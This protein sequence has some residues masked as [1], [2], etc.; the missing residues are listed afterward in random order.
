MM[1]WNEKTAEDYLMEI[2][3]WTRKKNTLGQVRDYLTEMGD[4]DE[5]LAI[6]HVAGTNGK[7]SVCADLT[8]ILRE[9]GFRVGTF[10]SPHLTN[11]RERFLID[12]QPVGQ[13][14]FQSAFERV[15]PV[16]ERMQARGYC[17]PTFFEYL[18][19]M[20]M[21]LFSREA[22][23]YVILETGLGGRLDTTNVIRHPLACVITSISLDHTAYLGDT[24]PAIAAEKAGIIKPNVPV[25]YDASEPA[26]APVIHAR[27]E[28][29]QAPAYPVTDQERYRQ[30]NFSAPYQERNAALAVK[31]LQVLQLPGVDET[32]CKRALSTVSWQG[33]MESLG[34]GI[35]LDGAHN[36][37]GIRAFL[38]AADRLPGGAETKNH[39]L[40]AAVADKDY[41]E[42]VTLLCQ[43]LSPERVTVAGLNSERGLAAS[44]LVSLFLQAG[45]PQ[46]E[47]YPDTRQALSAALAEKKE[48]DR[49][50]IVGSLYLIGEIKEIL[51]EQAA[52]KE[53]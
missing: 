28:E 4:P 29:L 41:R 27:A 1:I 30:G 35:W 46:A 24:I 52:H 31:V 47:G 39:L 17:H 38:E 26:A 40:F 45:C 32:V 13:A 7:G 18:F 48:T 50:L 15:A 36:P 49:L 33:R 9:A 51:S 25:I 3:L 53:E 22:V 44:E 37:G 42:M 12:G 19:L 10:V 14:A 21:E 16:A 34:N 43:G 20:A 2:P 5:Q 11:I 6:I 8:A 23:D